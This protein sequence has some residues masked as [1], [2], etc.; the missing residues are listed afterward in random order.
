MK[1]KMLVLSIVFMMALSG[2]A[3]LQEKSLP[4]AM[5]GEKVVVSHLDELSQHDNV[6]ITY[7]EFMTTIVLYESDD[8]PSLK[9]IVALKEKNP[10][11][12]GHYEL[13]ISLE[14]DHTKILLIPNLMK[15]DE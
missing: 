9:D 1:N 13:H 11:E 7:G 14:D 6:D 12:Y 10:D 4:V 15:N 2:C 8:G 3:L 5:P